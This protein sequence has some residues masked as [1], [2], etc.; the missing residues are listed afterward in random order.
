MKLNAAEIKIKLM[1]L[2]PK[3]EIEKRSKNNP[4]KKARITASLNDFETLQKTIKIK[5][6]SGKTP[7][8]SNR[9]TRVVCKI[10]RRNRV[11]IFKINFIR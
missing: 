8:M 6:K 4:A 7:K 5:T 9:G 11:I 1:I 2:A 10:A 3:T